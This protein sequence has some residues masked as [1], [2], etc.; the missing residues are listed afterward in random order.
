MKRTF[1]IG[2]IHGCYDELMALYKKLQN[3]VHLNPEEDI[4]VFVGDYIDRGLKT[5]SVISQMIRWQKK[6]PHWQFL[7]GNHEDLMLD[8]LVH[9]GRQ[10]HSYDL[11]WSQGGRE[12]FESYVPKNKTVY[13]KALLQVKDVIPYK[14]LKWLMDRPYYYETDKY[15]FVHGA[16]IPGMSLEGLKKKLDDPLPNEEKQAV[17]WGRDTFIFSKE[18]WGKKI[19]FGHTADYDGRYSVPPGAKPFQPIIRKN[20][21]G[22]D[23]AVCP[24]AS[25]GLTAVELP[26]EKFY[27]QESLS[28][29]QYL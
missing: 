8:A 25:N 3:E 21:I 18:D 11:W 2:D 24:S 5:K 12:T 22:I 29:L 27:F 19:I 28:Y 1:A 6:Y 4:L 17:I 20:K 23:T 14:H 16:V 9:K 26:S 15:F 7:F 10:Y 13:E